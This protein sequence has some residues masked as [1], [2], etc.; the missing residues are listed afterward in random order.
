MIGSRPVSR[1][2]ESEGYLTWHRTTVEGRPA[3]YG[4]G[5]ADGPPVVFLHG[6]ALGS[7]AYKRAIRRLTSRGCR[8]FAPALP[9]FGGTADLPSEGMTIAGYADWVA[10]FMAEVGIEEPALVIGHSFGGGVAIKLARSHPTLVRYLV[11]LNAVGNVDA[12]RPWEWALGFGREFWPPSDTLELVLAIRADLVPNF[13]RNPLGLAR[14]GFLAQ[15]ADLRVELAELKESGVPVLALHS[16]RDR[17][18][19]RSAFEAVCEAVGADRRVVSGG[20]AW[21]L[22]DPDSF[23]EV[24]ASTID[25][26]VAEHTASRAA[27]RRSEVE[28]LLKGTRLS[29]RSIQSLVGSAAPLW[30]LSDSAPA[31]AGD[32][33]LCRP[34]L[35]KDEVRALAR[36]IEDSTLVR[37]TIVARD[38]RGLLADSAAV[39]AAS[40]M[41]ISNASASTWKHQHL[42]LHSFIVGGGAQFDRKAWDALGERLRGM[43]GGAAPSPG[44]RPLRSV[45]VTVQ[46]AD[47]RSIVKVVAPDEQGL[48]A[49]ICRYFQV[50]DI[51]IETLQ[52]RTR[53]GLADDTF[54]VIG[55]VEADG[56]KA[57]LER[58]PVAAPRDTA[59]APTGAEREVMAGRGASRVGDAPL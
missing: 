8:V 6:W 25:V 12:R 44:L 26:Q 9:S 40:G 30:L 39:L 54:L 32:L 56:L 34:K 58:P 45:S 15:R 50:H 47:D 19:P 18:I 7:R 46:G 22:V 37:L 35:K 17:V 57:H 20:H 59:A 51:N 33:A 52:A 14:A 5:G 55:K 42:A 28:R 36:R 4:A 49:T 43:A 24:L 21:L 1:G 3:V 48:L 29:K 38:R 41:S 16:E 27:D 31:L 13:L 23:G 2:A 53:N 10:A 11:L